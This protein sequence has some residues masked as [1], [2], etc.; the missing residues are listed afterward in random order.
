MNPEHNDQFWCEQAKFEVIF[1]W[2]RKN[3]AS[4]MES[5]R[6]TKMGKFSCSGR[7]AESCPVGRTNEMPDF[8]KCDHFRS[9]VGKSSPPES[10]Q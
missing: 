8:K 5:D 1:R 10:L 4:G 9:L 6:Y 3:I 7:G 2:S